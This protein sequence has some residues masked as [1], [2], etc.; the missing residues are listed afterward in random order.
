MIYQITVNEVHRSIS[1][2]KYDQKYK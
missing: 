2:I 1:R